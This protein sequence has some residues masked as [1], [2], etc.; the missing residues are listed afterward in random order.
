MKRNLNGR[1]VF[2]ADRAKWLTASL[3]G[4]LILTISFAA[5]SSQAKRLTVEQPAVFTEP[6]PAE[7]VPEDVTAELG[8]DGEQQTEGATAERPG[9][10]DE[11]NSSGDDVLVRPVR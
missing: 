8:G 5:P 9:K 11:H 2:F 7:P 1:T 10:P 4:C 3:I 6:A